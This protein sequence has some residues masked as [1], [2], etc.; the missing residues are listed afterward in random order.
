MSS[1]NDTYAVAQTGGIGG[2]NS[3]SRSGPRIRAAAVAARAELLE[4]RVGAA[5]A[6]RSRA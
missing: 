6:C 4:A 2:S 1:A 5:S 3:M